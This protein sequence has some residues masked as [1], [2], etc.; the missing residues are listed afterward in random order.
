MAL[1]MYEQPNNPKYQQAEYYYLDTKYNIGA[2]K[3]K[4]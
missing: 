4:S 1:K 2:E 3:Y